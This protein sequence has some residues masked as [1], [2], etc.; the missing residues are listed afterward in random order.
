VAI[1]FAVH[2]TRGRRTGTGRLLLVAFV[3]APVALGAAQL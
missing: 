1:G 3:P 2:G